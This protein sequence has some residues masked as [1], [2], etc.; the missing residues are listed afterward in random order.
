MSICN[1]LR[2]FRRPS[3]NVTKDL[4]PL[5]ILPQHFRQILIFVDKDNF[6]R[7]TASWNVL[8]KK[9]LHLK[10]ILGAF[11]VSLIFLAIFK[12]I[13][14]SYILRREKRLKCCYFR[15]K[16]YIKSFHLKRLQ[17]SSNLTIF[18]KRYNLQCVQF[19]PSKTINSTWCICELSSC[20]F[21]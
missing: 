14:A 8:K 19:S 12:T 4:K 18:L 7:R 15:G 16:K 20:V 3:H 1:W 10:T 17:S 5:K 9:R 2:F 6:P 11:N 21:C 13:F